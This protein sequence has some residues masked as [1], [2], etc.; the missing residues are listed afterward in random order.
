MLG[1]GTLLLST[2]GEKEGETI[3]QEEPEKVL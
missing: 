3:G 1:L 2:K